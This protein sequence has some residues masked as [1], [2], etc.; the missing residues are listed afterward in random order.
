MTAGSS[1]PDFSIVGKNSISSALDGREDAGGSQQR[2]YVERT[3][4]QCGLTAHSLEQPIISY[5]GKDK[6]L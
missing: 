5:S 6:S 2:I 4:I 1:M 3:G